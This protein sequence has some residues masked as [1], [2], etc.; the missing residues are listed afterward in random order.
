MSHLWGRNLA[1]NLG[2]KKFGNRSYDMIVVIL[3][4]GV[5]FWETWFA[6]FST[7]LAVYGIE[8]IWLKFTCKSV[9]QRPRSE[10]FA[11]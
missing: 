3:Q 7:R 8:S 10:K 9:G 5:P 1:P 11:W 2:A 6:H 4:T